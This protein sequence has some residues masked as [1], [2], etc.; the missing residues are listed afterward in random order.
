MTSGHSCIG[1]FPVFVLFSPINIILTIMKIVFYLKERLIKPI[2]HDIL[3]ISITTLLLFFIA[4]YFNL[5]EQLFNWSRMW[6]Q[7]QADELLFPIIGFSIGLIWFSSR[8]YQEAKIESF[9]NTD[10]LLENRR[11]VRTLIETQERERL[12]LAQELHDVFAQYLTALRSQADLIQTVSGDDKV[13]I[14]NTAQQINNT[15]TKLHL[16]TRSLLKNLRPPL[17]DFGVAIAIEDLVTEW[18]KSNTRIQCQLKFHGDEL[19]LNKEELLTL[20]RSIQEGL[21]NISK[22]SKANHVD[23]ILSFHDQVP[24]SPNEVSLQIINNGETSIDIHK[25]NSGLGLIG[26]RERVSILNGDFDIRPHH[27]EGSELTL[28]FSLN[29]AKR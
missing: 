13:T 11:L 19:K 1:V 25:I 18:Q 12:F 15:V 2:S 22:H 6:E 27:P 26:I 14:N 7:Y 5:S 20:Y 21:S 17:L 23:I 10:L 28:R 3:I 9:K 29:S 24:H 16:V 8:R 4:R